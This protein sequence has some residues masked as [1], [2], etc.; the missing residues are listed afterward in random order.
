MILAGWRRRGEEAETEDHLAGN[1]SRV[2]ERG[3]HA[4]LAAHF[5]ADLPDEEPERTVIVE[6]LAKAYLAQAKSRV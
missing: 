4:A 5:D 1:P 3:V 6:A 2:D